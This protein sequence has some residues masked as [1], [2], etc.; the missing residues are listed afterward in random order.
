MIISEGRSDPRQCLAMAGESAAEDCLVRSG[1]R[2]VERRFRRKLGEIDII[3][4]DGEILVFVEV[5][6]RRSL[7]YGR[8]ADAVT[9][10]KQRHIARTA[11]AY[12]QLTG[13]GGRVCRF[14]VVEVVGNDRLSF[15]CNHIRDA[16]R[17]RSRPPQ[18]MDS[19]VDGIAL[20][21]YFPS[22]HMR[23]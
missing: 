15:R 8:P 6:T 10:C 14:D 1:M 2:I 23:E 7:D 11:L 18:G 3:A 19:G 5:K 13:Q 22:A 9:P 17:L 16:F 12:L 4:E 20:V 21:Q